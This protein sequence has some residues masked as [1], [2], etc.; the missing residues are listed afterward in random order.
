MPSQPGMASPQRR[1]CIVCSQ[2]STRLRDGAWP[3]TFLFLASP[4][5]QPRRT[6]RSSSLPSPATHMSSINSS[7]LLSVTHIIFVTAPTTSF[8][9]YPPPF[10]PTTSFT[11]CYIRT[12]TNCFRV[13]PALLL[14]LPLQFPVLSSHFLRLSIPPQPGTCSCSSSTA[15]LSLRTHSSVPFLTRFRSMALSF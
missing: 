10:V 2:C 14:S 1:T 7:P 8:C 3:V 4:S 13:T 15:L 5:W 12:L 6:L 9:H 11:D